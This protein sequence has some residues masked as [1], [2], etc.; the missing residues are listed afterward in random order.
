MGAMNGAAVVAILIPVTVVIAIC[1]AVFESRRIAAR[2]LEIEALANR[3][4]LRFT[5]GSGKGCAFRAI[6]DYQVDD[7]PF[8]IVENFEGFD[9]F[10]VGH[11]RTVEWVAT[12]ETGEL[13]WTL[14][15]YAYTTGSGKHRQRWFWTVAICSAPLVFPGLRIR[16]QGVLDT[17]GEAVGL[18]DLQFES[19]EFNKAFFVTTADPR[20]TYDLLHP[21]AMEFLLHSGRWPLQFGGSYVVCALRPRVGAMALERLMTDVRDFINLI[22]D[23]VRED[24]GL[25]RN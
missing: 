9:P 2:R 12:G 13:T 14:L 23:Y 7:D 4:G 22:P 21:E 3:L 10:G 11:S 18:R 17:I 25:D 8:G 16:K 24:M 20:R 1:A 6:D 5:P 15:D 19:E